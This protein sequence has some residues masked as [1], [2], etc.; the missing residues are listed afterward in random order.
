MPCFHFTPLIH[1]SEMP[2]C[3]VR[4]HQH[5]CLWKSWAAALE[6]RR[7]ELDCVI[8]QRGGK[9]TLKVKHLKSRKKLTVTI[10][11]TF[12]HAHLTW[13]SCG[14]AICTNSNKFLSLCVRLLHCLLGFYCCFFNFVRR[15]HQEQLLQATL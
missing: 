3:K 4:I 15:Q 2:W 9:E 1:S 5:E 8:P 14:N 13:N 10:A 6:F 11:V 7:W 12:T